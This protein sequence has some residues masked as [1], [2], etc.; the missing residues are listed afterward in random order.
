MDWRAE[1]F[2]HWWM[3]YTSAQWTAQQFAPEPEPEPSAWEIEKSRNRLERITEKVERRRWLPPLPHRLNGRMLREV[4]E[5]HELLGEA[6][7]AIQEAK[8]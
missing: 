7:Q 6:G 2:W 1:D 3:R 8:R 4:R 5:A